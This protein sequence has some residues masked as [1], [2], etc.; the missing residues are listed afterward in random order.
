MWIDFA[1]RESCDKMF[2]EQ[3]IYK[4]QMSWKYSLLTFYSNLKVVFVLTQNSYDF[5]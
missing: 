4:E 2:A 5:N 3:Y 1:Q